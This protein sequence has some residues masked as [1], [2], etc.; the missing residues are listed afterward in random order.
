MP[1]KKE[2]KTKKIVH[3]KNKCM[4]TTEKQRKYVNRND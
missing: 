2:K 3:N 4:K 1:R